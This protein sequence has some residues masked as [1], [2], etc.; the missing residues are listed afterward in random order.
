MNKRQIVWSGISI[1]ALVAA[2]GAVGP[3][4]AQVRSEA[5]LFVTN[6]AP[7]QVTQTSIELMVRDGEPLKVLLNGKA[8][9]TEQIQRNGDTVTILADDGSVAHV[10]QTVRLDGS[11][12]LQPG[13]PKPL[14]VMVG[15]RMSEPSESLRSQLKLGDRRVILIE[16]AIPGLPAA[17]AGIRT[18]DIIIAIDGNDDVTPEVL[19]KALMSKKPG[20][21]VQMR[22]LRGGERETFRVVVKQFDAS[23]MGMAE[24]PIAGSGLRAAQAP[25]AP[26]AATGKQEV[27][28]KNILERVRSQVNDEKL[29]AELERVLVEAMRASESA[30]AAAA[31]LHGQY[32]ELRPQVRDNMVEISPRVMTI[33]NPTGRDGT[34]VI[35][36]KNRVIEIPERFAGRFE[37]MIPERETLE[38]RLAEL[39]KR[40]EG[41]SEQM[42]A[43]MNRLIQRFEVMADQLERKLRSEN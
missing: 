26:S 40:M 36:D 5:A 1:G 15:I 14:P 4:H 11:H 19:Q 37:A 13:E 9:P 32:L 33:P 27:E 3:E 41:L 25:P 29:R 12:F 43:R 24:S 6:A 22:V 35:D 20:D 8:V 23:R 18:H 39:E 34:F 38:R 28:L 10:Q 7:D 42:E 16:E 30:R 17:E 31:Q 2:A 21:V